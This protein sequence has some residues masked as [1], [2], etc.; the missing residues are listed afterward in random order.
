MTKGEVL[1]TLKEMFIERFGVGTEVN[2]NKR[3]E[4]DYSWDVGGTYLTKVRYNGER[5]EYYIECW[6]GDW[7][8]KQSVFN[9]YGITVLS[10]CLGV[11]VRTRTEYFIG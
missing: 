1:V 8:D 3:I 10:D 5:F 7:E 4:I 2:V 6:G 9:K 11:N